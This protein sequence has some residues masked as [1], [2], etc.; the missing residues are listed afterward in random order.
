MKNRDLSILMITL[1]G[2]IQK[3]EMEELKAKK[4]KRYDGLLAE[5]KK[6]AESEGTCLNGNEQKGK[7]WMA[8]DGLYILEALAA[9]GLRSI[10][11]FQEIPNIRRLIVNDIADAAVASMK[12]NFAFNHLTSDRIVANQAYSPHP[13]PP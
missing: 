3:E 1:F 13:L 2:Q 6:V 11:Y 8:E 10:R 9:S 7:P 4:P 5:R 12:Q